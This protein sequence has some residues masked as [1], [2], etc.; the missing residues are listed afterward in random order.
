MPNQVEKIASE[1]MGAVKSAKASFEH[2]TGVFKELTREHGEVSALL[3]RVKMTSDPE[4]RRNL[5]PTIREKLLAHEKGELSE[6]YPVFR[7]YPELAPFAEQHEREAGALERMLEQLSVTG[8]AEPA[9][10]NTFK[11][12]VSAVQSH[13]KEEE[14]EF[15]PAASKTLGKE[16]T[17]EMKTRY[18][19]TKGL[20]R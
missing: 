9:W 14:N 13:V 18:L 17:E 12:L 7:R 10:A 20:G 19:A 2:L 11:E 4:V 15:F 8:Y 1:V 3:S 6:V 16:M 5:F